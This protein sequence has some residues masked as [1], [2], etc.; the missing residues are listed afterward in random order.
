M[1][2]FRVDC[3][4]LSK[5]NLLGSWAKKQQ[6]TVDRYVNI[7]FHLVEMKLALTHS[8]T[9]VC[10]IIIEGRLDA[11]LDAPIGHLMV[12]R[13]QWI[14]FHYSIVNSWIAIVFLIPEVPPIDLSKPFFKSSERSFVKIE[15]K[16]NTKSVPSINNKSFSVR[17]NRFLMLAQLAADVSLLFIHLICYF[18][19]LF[20]SVWASRKKN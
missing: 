10:L 12:F 18:I 2:K 20:S 17:E 11:H 9:F 16:Q 8:L 5:S 19:S 7:A 1:Q 6:I 3:A 4:K 14:N 13:H 15:W